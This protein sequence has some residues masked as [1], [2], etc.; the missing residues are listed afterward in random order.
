M[1]RLGLVAQRLL[2]FA[3]GAALIVMMLHITAEVLLR[4]VFG[5][6][7]PGT[8]ELVSFYYMVCAVF[9]GL[10][11]VAV[12]NEQVIVEIFLGWMPARGLRLVDGLAALLGAAYAGLLTYGAWLEARAALRFD[13]IVPVRGFDLPIWPMRWLA[14]A[15]LA[16]IALASIGHAVAHLRKLRRKA[17]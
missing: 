4:A 17:P 1:T 9:A 5:I 7:I 6:T 2:V 13:E 16:V 10:A 11:I 12:L 8:L 3:G 15:G 14:C